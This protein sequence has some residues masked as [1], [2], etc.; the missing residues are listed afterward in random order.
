LLTSLSLK[1]LLLKALSLKAL[2]LITLSLKSISLTALLPKTLSQH[3]HPL[4]EVAPMS[5]SSLAQPQIQHIPE[6]PS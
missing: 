4:I 6:V 3:F 1:A 5:T 2:L